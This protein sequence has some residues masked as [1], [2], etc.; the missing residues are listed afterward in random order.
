M[1]VGLLLGN[2]IL[3]RL[4]KQLAH[5]VQLLQQLGQGPANDVQRVPRQ[6][7]Q[8]FNHLLQCLVCFHV[9]QRDA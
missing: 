5:L 6:L 8:R 1:G 4:T 7:H 3:P 9:C 2:E